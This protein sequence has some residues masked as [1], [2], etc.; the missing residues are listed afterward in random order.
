MAADNARIGYKANAKG[1]KGITFLLGG[2]LIVFL[3]KVYSF[4]ETHALD[5]ATRTFGERV[6]IRKDFPKCGAV[7]GKGVRIAAD[8]IIDAQD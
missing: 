7:I 6:G 4:N 8:L 2:M 5:K 3:F 1:W